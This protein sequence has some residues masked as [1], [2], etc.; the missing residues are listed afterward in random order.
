MTAPSTT[1]PRQTLAGLRLI[2]AGM[3]IGQIMFLGVIAFVS[4]G[5]GDPELLQLLQY[6]GLGFMV[7]A[8]FAGHVLRNQVYKR[9]WQGHAVSP[10]G[11]ATGN[12]LL[13]ALWEGVSLLALVTALLA[14]AFW[15][16][17]IPSAVAG[18]MFLINWPDGKPMQAREPD[19]RP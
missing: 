9:H 7:V 15:P 10:Q 14:G 8:L 18:V 19:L 12:I 3:L 2:W 16:Y 4:V 5:P 1:D 11:Y 17:I 13:F 6:I